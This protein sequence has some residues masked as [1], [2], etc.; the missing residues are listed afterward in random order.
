MK[1]GVLGCAG[2]AKN[3]VIPAM[4]SIP[5]NQLIAVASRAED[6]AAEFSQ[7][8]ACEPIVGYDN[9]LA[10]DDIEAVYIP[11]PTGM[12]MEWVAKALE[13]GKH[14]LVEK[15]AGATLAEAQQMIALAE[16]HNVLLVENFQFQHHSQHQFVFDQIN[17]GE[18]GEI[19]C[20]RSS[21][22][23]PPFSIDSN[24]RYQKDLAGGALLDAGGYVLKATSFML[25]QSFDVKAAHLTY[26][27][28]YG[29]DWYGGAFLVNETTGI[30]A[31]VA[32][33]FDNF[34]QCNYEIWGSKGKIT[35]TRAF[36]AKKDFSP[37]I[38]LETHN[39][40]RE[41]NLPTD[42]HFNNM[43][44]Y[45]NQLVKDQE[46]ESERKKLLTQAELLQ[47]VKEVATRS[48]Q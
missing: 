29:V 33:G 2:I 28:E 37:T 47:R 11:L 21:F 35:A 48:L 46:F 4:L 17:S 16:K 38:I 39:K 20:F 25:G 14:V 36:T 31:E 24:I 5:G 40:V 6:K 44:V 30:I 3:S 15:A 19:R 32:F 10:L 34:Y 45:F 8:F 7:L 41:I 1:W 23:F 12:H 18:I 26:K 27:Q 13:Q 43:L 42:D 9:L 22:G